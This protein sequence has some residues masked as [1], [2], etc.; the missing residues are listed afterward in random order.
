MNRKSIYFAFMV[1]L[2]S[3]PSFGQESTEKIE[4]NKWAAQL[5]FQHQDLLFEIDFGQ[6]GI[7]HDVRFRPFFT[8]EIQRF[9]FT[10]NPNRHFFAVAELGHYNNLY[11]DRWLSFKLGLGSQRRI[12]NFFIASRLQAGL[13]RTRRGD[14]QYVLEDGKWVVATEAQPITVDLLLSPRIDVGYRIIDTKN[15]IDLF[16]NYQ[17]TLYASA[18]LQT[19]IPYH[20][21]GF[22]IRY[23]F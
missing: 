23:G 14:I 18:V 4:P 15:P 1:F 7:A 20:G 5:N 2:F 11:H 21:Y 13:S 12:G 3:F 6:L 10:K 19:A 17:M 9:I 22:G 8:A 16:A